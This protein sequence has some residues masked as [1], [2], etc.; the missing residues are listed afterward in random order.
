MELIRIAPDKE[1]ARNIL[2]MVSLI[3]ERIMEQDRKRMAA[4]IISDYYEIGSLENQEIFNRA[5]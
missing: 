3:E 4:L 2:K 1:K 5:P